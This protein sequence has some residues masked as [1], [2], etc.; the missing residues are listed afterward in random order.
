MIASATTPKLP[1]PYKSQAEANALVA[2]AL[3]DFEIN[4]DHSARRNVLGLLLSMFAITG[5]MDFPKGW[6]RALMLAFDAAGAVPPKADCVR[7]YK[8]KLTVDPG[9][10]RGIRYTFDCP[11]AEALFEDLERKAY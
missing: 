10:F 3:E 2:E 11:D 1:K 9:Q 5:S 8:G 6:V 4:P 7:W